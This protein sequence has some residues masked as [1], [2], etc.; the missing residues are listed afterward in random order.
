ML[1]DN[2]GHVVQEPDLGADGYASDFNSRQPDTLKWMEV[3]TPGGRSSLVLASVIL[4]CTHNP[5]PP[6]H[7]VLML[8][9]TK[10][11]EGPGI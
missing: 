4:P 9:Q 8:G 3:S 2:D 7:I 6:R 1:L 5:K 10:I 11:E